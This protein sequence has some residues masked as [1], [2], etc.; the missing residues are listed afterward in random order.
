[1]ICSFH[2]ESCGNSEI[3]TA[4]RGKLVRFIVYKEIYLLYKHH[5]LH[6]LHFTTLFSVYTI[7]PGEGA[8]QLPAMCTNLRKGMCVCFL[9][10]MLC[11]VRS[12]LNLAGKRSTGG[13]QTLKDQHWREVDFYISHPVSFFNK[14]SSGFCD[15]E[16]PTVSAPWLQHVGSYRHCN[17]LHWKGHWLHVFQE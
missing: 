17:E 3:A 13:G 7:W 4:A 12:L 1:M 14:C 2:C 15:E 11:S 6:Q 16:G 8:N 10:T 9:P 5:E